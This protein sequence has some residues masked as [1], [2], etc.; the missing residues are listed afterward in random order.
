M[1]VEE[2][3]NFIAKFVCLF[4]FVFKQ[5]KNS[6]FAGHF[7]K[8]KKEKE[9]FSV[10]P[11]CVLSSHH[12]SSDYAKQRKAEQNS[13]RVSLLC[14][15]KEHLHCNYIS[16]TLYPCEEHNQREDGERIGA[17]RIPIVVDAD[18]FQLQGVHYSIQVPI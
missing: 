18:R 2:V 13:H 10:L 7:G 3:E 8:R 4:V 5:K 14:V 16:Q 1:K 9:S 12:M 15:S 17:G 11:F 6:A